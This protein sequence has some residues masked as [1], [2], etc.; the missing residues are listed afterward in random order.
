MIGVLYGCLV[1][2]GFLCGLAMNPDLRERHAAL[3][4]SGGI[5]LVLVPI[6][7]WLP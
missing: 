7:W 4:A 2:G 1:V 6:V 3:L 5:A